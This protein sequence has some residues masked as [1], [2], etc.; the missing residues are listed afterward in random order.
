MR[1]PPRG[2]GRFARGKELRTQSLYRGV[3]GSSL[4]SERN[5][6]F[7]GES[8][9][10]GRSTCNEF[11]GLTLGAG[12]WHMVAMTETWIHTLVVLVLFEACRRELE[13]A[14]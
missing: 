10:E 1:L 4:R 11:G 2:E 13:V 3:I 9:S 8:T 5:N 6:G 14:S 7:A 12:S